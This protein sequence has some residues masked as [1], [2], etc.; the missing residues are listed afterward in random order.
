LHCLDI[1]YR[2][3]RKSNRCAP[4]YILKTQCLPEFF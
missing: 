2:N 1:A 3:A 4:E